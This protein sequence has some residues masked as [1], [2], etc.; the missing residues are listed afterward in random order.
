MIWWHEVLLDFLILACFA[1][2]LKVTC[3]WIKPSIVVEPL[4]AG[5]KLTGFKSLL[6]T[7]RLE[8]VF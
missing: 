5:A 6:D 4:G 2:S 1:Q 8:I 3:V 7:P